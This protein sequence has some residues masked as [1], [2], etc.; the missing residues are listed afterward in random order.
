MVVFEYKIWSGARDLN[1]GPHGPE[2]YAVSSTQTVFDGF[3]FNSTAHWAISSQ[4]QSLI[5]P[6]L[7]HELL[8]ERPDGPFIVIAVF[9]LPVPTQQQWP[10]IRLRVSRRRPLRRAVR[11]QPQTLLPRAELR[12][13]S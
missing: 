6:G 13:L 2:I 10:C 8:H 11:P 1:P 4:F 5:S 9:T 3:E 12:S 7:L